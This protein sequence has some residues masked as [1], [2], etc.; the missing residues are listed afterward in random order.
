L[1]VGF[2]V[3]A[4]FAGRLGWNG[5]PGWL[6][7]SPVRFLW[8][9]PL[10]MV[11]QWFMGRLVPVFGPDTSAGVLPMPH[12]LIYYAIFFG[13]GALY[14]D[15]DD[16]TGRAGRGWWIS[17]PVG[18]IVVFPLGLEFSSG[19]VG[20]SDSIVSPSLL[21]LVSSLL[22]VAYA[23]T[24]I[25]GLMGL[26]RR[27]SA[28]ESRT[29]RYFS[30]ASYWLYLAHLPLVIGAQIWVRD[31]PLPAIVKFLLVCG[32]TTGILLIAY[33]TLVRST[34]LGRFLNGPRER[35]PRRPSSKPPWVAQ[36]GAWRGY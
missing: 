18:L 23:W 29:I 28:K 1:V 20:A 30:D 9:I 35:P 32:A 25:F 24:M 36:P 8:L 3:Y 19:L 5:L 16:D 10:T 13:F 15:S 6:I 21:H 31:W 22:Q 7:L 12:V 34:W 27:L 11:P 14:F 4:F 17:L 26:F 2:G 33:Q